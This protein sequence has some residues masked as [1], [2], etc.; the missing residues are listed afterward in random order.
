MFFFIG[1]KC[2]I[3]SQLILLAAK[4]R[5]RLSLKMKVLQGIVLSLLVHFFLA[6][7][8]H[9]ANDSTRL[10]EPNPVTIDIQEH[11]PQ[12]ETK[13]SRQIVRQTEPPTSE[14]ADSSD[15]SLTFLSE[16]SQRVKK[17]T[18]AAAS[19]LT[20]NRS[21]T[22][23]PK[24]IQTRARAEAR[25]SSSKTPTDPRDLVDTGLP[26]AQSHSQAAPAQTT[27]DDSGISTVGEALPQELAVGS[28]TALNT[29]RYLYYSF[30]SRVESLI[31]FRWETSVQTAMD[32]G[33]P[34]RGISNSSGLWVTQLLVTLKKNGELNSVL[35]MKESGMKSFDLA[36]SQAFVQARL[37]PKPPKEMVE[38]DGLIRLKYSFQVRYTPKV[39]V[40]SRE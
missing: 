17:Q 14:K 21:Q 38:E 13:K 20:Q 27:F 18:R 24:P 4:N 28:F 34:D 7:G 1:R 33:L 12:N 9:Q 22:S 39:L 25:N 36:A 19:G 31:R 37:F 2:F 30:F 11:P 26:M 3:F 40:K 35:M 32:Q 15:D 10:S 6:L 5:P 23:A 8:L 16:K 29:D